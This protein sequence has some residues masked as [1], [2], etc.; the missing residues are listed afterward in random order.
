[1]TEQP[2]IS[3]D[4]PGSSD[5]SAGGAPGGEAAEERW[6]KPIGR[7]AVLSILG[8]GALGTLFGSHVQS[9]ISNLLKSVHAG[10]VASLLP[11]GGQFTIYTI[12]NGYPAAA[13]DYRL[14]V[15]G[16]VRR[17]LSLRVADLQSLPAT[18]LARNFQCVTG[19]S[20]ADV[21][22]VGV[23]LVDLAER[24]EVDQAASA[25]ELTSFD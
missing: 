8:L 9:G 4:A 24:A 16:L 17:P 15:A 6:S 3:P 18:R 20:V 22:W 1:M 2:P 19:W 5:G 25:F 12:T 10:G 21:H 13:A 7:R 14:R 23:R 11:G